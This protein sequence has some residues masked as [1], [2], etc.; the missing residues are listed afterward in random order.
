MR[1]MGQVLRLE[2]TPRPS[3][4]TDDSSPLATCPDGADV[5][6]D[7]CEPRADLDWRTVGLKS[8]APLSRPR[9]HQGGPT[10][11]ELRQTPGWGGA[12]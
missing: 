9:V 12:R 3:L 2:A 11:G 7:A 10:T 4:S 6:L 5:R 8:S 1:A